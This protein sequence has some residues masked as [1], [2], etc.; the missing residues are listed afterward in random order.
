M[1]EPEA[2]RCDVD[3]SEEAFGGL[4]VAGGDAAEVLDPAEGILDEVAPAVALLIIVD[5]ALAIAPA[6]DDRT[7]A[8]LAQGLAQAVGIVAFV[9][10]QVAHSACTF[11]Q[12][13]CGLHVADIAGGQHQRVGPAQHVGQG[14]DL[15]CPAAARTAD[16]L[17][18]AP[19]FPPN[20]ER[21]ALM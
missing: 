10:K 11:E 5:G 14:V 13:R 3:E 16:R 20:A 7:G 18:L 17:R 9:A 21:W 6:G 4:V 8:I 2:D 12:R 19:P 15:G 1:A